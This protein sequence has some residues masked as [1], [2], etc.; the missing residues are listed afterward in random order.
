MM[1]IDERKLL[2][3][4]GNPRG[5]TKS[6]PPITECRSLW[7]CKGSQAR[8]EECLRQSTAFACSSFAAGCPPSKKRCPPIWSSLSNVWTGFSGF[9]NSQTDQA[10]NFL[11]S[12]LLISN[13]LRSRKMS[14]FPC[15]KRKE[16]HVSM[17]PSRGTIPLRQ[18]EVNGGAFNASVTGRT[19][20]LSVRLQP[21]EVPAIPLEELKEITDNFGS[22]ALIGGSAVCYGILKS[23]KAAALKKLDSNK[24]TDHEFLAM[25]SMIS[26]L[27]H[28]N[29]VELLGY[30]VEGN[31]RVLAYEFATMASLHD[32]L[33]GL[34]GV[35]GARPGPVLSWAQRVKIAVG[36]AKGLEYLHQADPPVIHR[37][38]KSCT[39]LLF[40]DTVAKIASFYLSDQS[41]DLMVRLYSTRVLGNF[42]YHAPEF[43]MT[44]QLTTKSDVYSFGVV[45]LELLTGRKP[46][47]STLPRGQQSLLTWAAPRLI[48]DRVRECVDPRLGGEYPGN[49]V[50]KLA[51]VIALCVQFEAKMR[52]NMSIVASA[53][54]SLLSVGAAGPAN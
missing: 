3:T 44:G 11:L 19:S 27:K 35:K 24:Q 53:L 16:D 29:V 41:P 13:V 52:P 32:V 31:L 5:L 45:L 39:V 48:E 4:R 22:K 17:V 30:C 46:I 34:K 1:I 25:V 54:E 42:G 40:D 50:A 8:R 6:S 43:T 21:I 15:F 9:Q 38:I 12:I 51:A 26:R 10:S 18:S 2:P 23:K 7:P 37:D 14:C 33:H 49:A 36:V 20:P 28:A 47:D